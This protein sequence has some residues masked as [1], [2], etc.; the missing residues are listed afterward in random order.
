MQAAITAAERGHD[1]VLCEKTTELG[2][3]MKYAEEVSFKEDLRRFK[4]Y[5]VRRIR[6]LG[7]RVLLQTEVTRELVAEEAPDVLVA[8]VGAK[9][10]IPVLPGVEKEFVVLATA[11]YSPATIVGERVEVAGGGLVG[12]ETALHL[13]Q[14]GKEVEILE[15]L[16]DI[17]LDANLMHRRALL[18]ELQKAVTVHTATRCVEIIEGGAIAAGLNGTQVLHPCDTVVIACG[19]KPSLDVVDSL[20]DCA[21]DFIAVGDCV[22]PR[23]ILNAVRTGYDAAMSIG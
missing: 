13:A 12:C 1:V 9:P 22:R 6:S 19:Y 17:A 11:V 10:V 8:A 23:R 2:G 20:A 14:L 18:L 5:Q 7:V 21:P 4:D 16:D 3:A 15:M